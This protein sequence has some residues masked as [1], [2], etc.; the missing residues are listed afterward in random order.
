[1]QKIISYESP[2][3]HYKAKLAV[4]WC[5]DNRFWKLFLLY[6][7]EEEWFDPIFVAGG[8]KDLASPETESD[9][10]YAVNQFAKSIKLH[11]PATIALMAHAECGAYGKKF[12]NPEEERKFYSEELIKAEAALLD[13]P[14]LLKEIK[15]VRLYADFEGLYKV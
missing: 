6:I 2:H 11:N 13:R 14:F 9:R 12:N 7:Q 15:I 1:M 5:F 10:E 4:N 8:A 3:E